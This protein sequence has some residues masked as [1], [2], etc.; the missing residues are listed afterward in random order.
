MK[1]ASLEE[2]RKKKYPQ[3]LTPDELDILRQIDEQKDIM[4]TD[5]E[6]EQSLILPEEPIKEIT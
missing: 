1:V 3:Y 5:E 6:L 4:F 2:Y